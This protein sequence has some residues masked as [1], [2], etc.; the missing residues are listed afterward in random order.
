MLSLWRRAVLGCV[1]AVCALARPTV[2]CVLDAARAEQSLAAARST[3][4][5]R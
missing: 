1:L 2:V 4:A 5:L 3:A